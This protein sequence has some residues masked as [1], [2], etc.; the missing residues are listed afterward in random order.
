MPDKIETRDGFTDDSEG[1][2]FIIGFRVDD[3]MVGHLQK[4]HPVANRD[5]HDRT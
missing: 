1:N 3:T 4:N 2:A 5:H